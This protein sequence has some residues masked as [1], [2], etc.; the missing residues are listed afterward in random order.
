[1]SNYIMVATAIGKCVINT[2][3]F[4]CIFMESIRMRP[5][6][7]RQLTSIAIPEDSQVTL[8]RI[9][10][11]IREHLDAFQKEQIAICQ[12]FCQIRDQKLYLGVKKP[13]FVIYCADVWGWKGSQAYNMAAAGEAINFLISNGEKVLPQSIEQAAALCKVPPEDR[14]VAWRHF[15]EEGVPL[16]IKKR[17][18]SKRVAAVL[19]NQ[20]PTRSGE[21]SGVPEFHLASEDGDQELARLGENSGTPE[22]RLASEDGD[23]Q[24]AGLVEDS[25]TLEFHLASEDGDRQLAGLVENSGTPEFGLASE[26]G[27][28]EL[29]GLVENS[30]TPEFRL[31]SEDGDRQQMPFHD[32]DEAVSWLISEFDTNQLAIAFAKRLSKI[33]HRKFRETFFSLSTTSEGNAFDVELGSTNSQGAC[34]PVA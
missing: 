2:K 13:N 31:A 10:K 9:E 4:E 16:P 11:E 18:P 30:G 34:R 6:G 19:S 8:A 21:D 26:D 20:K 25:G 23:R 3:T 7:Q 12:L 27:D 29:T 28:R 24:L 22:F 1:M 14:L 15:H 17:N 33:D 5:I 32:A